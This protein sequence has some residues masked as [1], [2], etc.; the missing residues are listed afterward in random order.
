MSRDNNN[1]PDTVRSLIRGI[2]SCADWLAHRI[3]AM[4]PVS[5]RRKTLALVRVD[6]IGDYILS[7]NFISFIKQSAAYKDYDIF[8]VGNELWK[9]LSLHLDGIYFLDSL[10]INKKQFLRN[11]LYRYYI[12]FRLRFMAVEIAVNP[13][14]SRDFVDDAIMRAINAGQKIGYRG[15]AANINE[16]LLREGN[17][18]YSTFIGPSVDVPIF[19]FYRNKDF[20]SQLLGEH[21]DISRPSLTFNLDDRPVKYSSDNNARYVVVF[22]GGGQAFKIW[23]YESYGEIINY[24]REKHGH[25]IYIAGSKQDARHAKAI[26]KYIKYPHERITNATGALSLVDL[27]Y[28][29]SQASLYVGS[30]TGAAHLCAC[31]GVPVISFFTGQ[32]FGRFAPYPDDFQYT[33]IPLYPP[34]VDLSKDRCQENSLLFRYSSPHT[35]QDILP[36]VVIPHIDRL[37]MRDE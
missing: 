21:L 17:K 4:V 12:F 5:R 28:L 15:D 26:L 7:R 35:I 24:L 18:I 22:P 33:F 25:H 30:D 1:Q 36:E 34:P 29:L 20:F 9:D 23:N 16:N 13:A 11:P 32:H 37:L 19:E 6:G 10:W 14:Y 27:L 8:F 3:L 31:S 2:K